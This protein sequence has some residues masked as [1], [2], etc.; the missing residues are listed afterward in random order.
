M[1]SCSSGGNAL[2]AFAGRRA[3]RELTTLL[4]RAP[5][6]AHRRRDGAVEEVPVD[7][8]LL[9]D[10]VVVRPG[11]V[12]PVD[13]VV[14]RRG[15][16]VDESALT[17]EPLPVALRRA[18][19]VRSGTANAGEA[20]ELR[21]DPARRGERVRGIVRLVRHAETQRA[22]FVRMADRY[23][24]VFLPRDARDGWRRLGR[25]RGDAVRAWP[26]SSSRRRAR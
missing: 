15:A 16:V 4:E 7:E 2:E 11:E 3:R 5:R 20:F 23:A 19:R 26:C 12:V 10:V 14:R 18:E 22:P 9:G 8:L 24:V 13:G 17:G 1:L 6:I 21:A 25:R